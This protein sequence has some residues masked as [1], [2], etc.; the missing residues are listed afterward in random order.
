MDVRRL[1]SKNLFRP[2]PRLEDDGCDIA[3]RGT[4][5][6]EV[7]ALLLETDNTVLQIVLR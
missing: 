3:K 5:G 7:Q 4:G 6:G 1:D 2:H